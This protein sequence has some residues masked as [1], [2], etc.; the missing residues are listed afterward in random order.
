MI[1]VSLLLRQNCTTDVSHIWMIR[2][3]VD[4]S[5]KVFYVTALIRLGLLHPGS[6]PRGFLIDTR[7]RW[8]QCCILGECL[9]IMHGITINLN[10]G[11][12]IYVRLI[13][14]HVAIA[15]IWIWCN[16]YFWFKNSKIKAYISMTSFLQI[17]HL[18]CH[19]FY[20]PGDIFPMPLWWS[21]ASGGLLWASVF[22]VHHTG[23]SHNKG[24]VMILHTSIQKQYKGK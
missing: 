3:T 12:M 7:K 20:T 15:N 8:T 11:T 22:A 23:F 6:V 18:H 1:N 14:T 2:I 13:D 17:A 5:H 24:P 9:D 16:L 19:I 10:F 21:M 4:K